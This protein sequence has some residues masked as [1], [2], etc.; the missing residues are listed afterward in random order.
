MTLEGTVAMDV[1]LLESA[2]TTPPAGAG[3]LRVTVPVDDVPPVALDGFNVSEVRTGGST[4]M[5]AVCVTPLKTAERIAVVDAATG[6][7]LTAN[8]VLAVPSGMVTVAGSVT[9]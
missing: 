7:V 6:L 2:A 8:V 5:E 4:V 3:P 9:D 1:L